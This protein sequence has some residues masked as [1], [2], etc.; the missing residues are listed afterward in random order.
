MR[1]R[2]R[3]RPV[4][5]LLAAGV[6][7]AIHPAL[8]DLG[9]W[10]GYFFPITEGRQA[11]LK[12]LTDQIPNVG[13]GVLVLAAM[14]AITEEFA[15]R[16]YIQSGL[17]RTYRPTTAILLSAF[18][19]AFLHAL[20]SL[21]QQFFPAALLGLILGAI[22]Y[23]TGSLW[24]GVVLHLM[25]NTL[26]VFV[27]ELMK[28]PGL[29]SA[30]DS[31][32]ATAPR[33]C[34]ACRS[35]S[36]GLLLAVVLLALILPGPDARAVGRP[37]SPIGRP[38]ARLTRPAGASPMLTIRAAWVFPVTSPPIPDGCVTIDG[39]R[40]ARVGPSRP[41]GDGRPRPRSGGD[42]PGVRQRPHPPRT[43]ADPVGRVRRARG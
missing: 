35:S 7:L 10:V 12:Q 21:F 23:R 33:G 40:I 32:S 9:A 36:A 24:P 38:D 11:L 28:R 5:L 25:N 2:A 22:C 39:D 20:I 43:R 26:G 18:L 6:A 14:P 29:G 13:V 42:R 41:G 19:F 1:V 27:P 34:S 31:S 16:G 30:A 37:R 4:D 8:H 15:F 3:P 17:L